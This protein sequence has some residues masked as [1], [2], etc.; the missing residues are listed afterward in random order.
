MVENIDLALN[1]ILSEE[2]ETF[3]FSKL[4]LDLYNGYDKRVRNIFSYLHQNLNSLIGFMNDKSKTNH[5]FNSD[6]SRM[7]IFII[8]TIDELKLM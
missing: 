4:Y 7:L 6:E 8:E 5:H 1:N 3:N 2:I